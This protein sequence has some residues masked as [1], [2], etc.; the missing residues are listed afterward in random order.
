MGFHIFCYWI[1]GRITLILHILRQYEVPWV[2]SLEGQIGTLLCYKIG[3]LKGEE[4]LSP[5]KNTNIMSSRR[6]YPGCDGRSPGSYLWA[7]LTLQLWGNKSSLLWASHSSAIKWWIWTKLSSS[8][9]QLYN[10]DK[11]YDILNRWEPGRTMTLRS[12]TSLT[13]S[14]YLQYEGGESKSHS[15]DC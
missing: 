4:A 1:F 13:F 15:Q 6:K 14:F 3:C 11:P 8:L 2:E 9:F 12:H 10:K 5:W 7:W